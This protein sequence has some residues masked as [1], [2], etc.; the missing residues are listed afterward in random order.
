M[1]I[2]QDQARQVLRQQ[3]LAQA[4]LTGYARYIDIPGVPDDSAVDDR[5][6]TVVETP[7]ALHHVFMLNSLQL[8]VDGLLLYDP[9]AIDSPIDYATLRGETVEAHARCGSR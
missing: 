4:T 8:L 3:A 2:T 1:T 7:L 5:T 6:T 9:Q